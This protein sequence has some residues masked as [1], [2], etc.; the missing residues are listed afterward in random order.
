V[1]DIEATIAKYEQL[2]DIKCIKRE[3]YGPGLVAIAWLP[4][5]ST[6]IELLQPLVKDNMNAEFLRMH[7]E[8]VHHLAI[9]VDDV[10]AELQAL[11]AK[12]IETMYSEVRSGASGLQVAF[13]NKHDFGGALIEICQK[14][15][16][17]QR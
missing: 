3:E 6:M 15:S 5:G 17:I 7:G 4:L 13:I 8:G 9:E 10:K 14:N 2:L 1:Y 11:K 12:N 16:L